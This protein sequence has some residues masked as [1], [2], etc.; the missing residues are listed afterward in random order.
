MGRGRLV[1][2]GLNQTVI[3]KLILN[4]VMCTGV[5]VKNNNGSRSDDWIY[6]PL[7]VQLHLFT[8]NTALSLIYT[9]SASPLHTH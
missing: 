1:N 8:I 9:L 5:R 7:F 6:G 4:I 3:L 2:L